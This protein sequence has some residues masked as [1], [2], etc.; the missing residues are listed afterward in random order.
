MKNNKIVKIVTLVLSCLLLIGAAI[1]IS[2]SATDEP[3][4]EI[5]AKNIS[6]EGAIKIL[7]A[8]DANNVPE[9]AEV[10]M[11]F[12]TDAEGDVAYEKAAHSEDITIGTETYK[13]FFSEGIAP[14]NMR[15]PLYA[16][17]VIVDAE[18]SVLAESAL[19]EYSIYTYAINRYLKAPTIDQFLLYSA[20]LDY[21][22]SVQ[23]MLVESG[24]MTE[25]DVIDNGGWANAYCGV[26]VATVYDGQV[27]ATSTPVFAAPGE[28]VEVT[29]PYGYADGV[30]NYIADANGK[31]ITK[32]GYAKGTVK[33]KNPG[34]TTCTANYKITGFSVRTFDDLCIDDTENNVNNKYKGKTEF[35]AQNLVGTYAANFGNAT[36]D[37]KYQRIDVDSTDASNNVYLV[38]ANNTAG[39]NAFSYTLDRVYEGYDKYVMQFDFNWH[40]RTDSK[41]D[42]PVFFRVD[43]KALADANDLV[44]LYL[45]DSGTASTTYTFGNVTLN[46]GEKYTLRFELIPHNNELYNLYLYVNGELAKEWINNSP[47]NHSSAANAISNVQYFYGMRFF[48]RVATDY[49]CEIDNVYVAAEGKPGNGNG[50][51]ADDALTYKYN[52][53]TAPSDYTAHVTPGSAKIADNAFTFNGY[54]ESL[55]IKNSGSKI[56]TK[57]VYET[58][59]KF[60][61]SAATSSS[62]TIAWWGLSASSGSKTTTFA[63]YTFQYAASNGKVDYYTIYRNDGGSSNITKLFPEEW[64]N[65]RIEYTPTT[66]YNGIVEF[67]LN[68]VLLTTYTASGYEGRGNI[69]NAKLDCVAH[70]FRGASY[71]GVSSLKISYA[72]TYLNATSTNTPG[73]GVYYNNAELAGTRYDGTELPSYVSSSTGTGNFKVTN[74]YI[75]TKGAADGNMGANFGIKNNNAVEGNVH[76]FEADI[77]LA[78]G[79]IT[80]KD[81]FGWFGMVAS[82]TRNKNE[83]FVS[84]SASFNADENNVITGVN[85]YDYHQNSTLLTT[86]DVG[87]WYNIR[88]VYTVTGEGKGDVE[89]Y[90]DNVLITSYSTNGYT[91]SDSNTEANN[92]FSQLYFE[93]R[94]SGS[95]GAYYVEFNVDNMFLGSF[96]EE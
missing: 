90:V 16:K 69:S 78:K 25:Q 28:E 32:N 71:S 20:T 65:I 93:I 45:N 23:K 14:K 48:N 7:Y 44:L 68:G 36:T 62:N 2:V 61:A 11:Y 50:I 12:Y 57:Y 55:G 5:K 87:K 83:E 26:N 92:M 51:Y 9:G 96:T 73:Q 60:S 10:K 63:S 21:G 91:V 30:F 18:G 84:L 52:D 24:R 82:D 95:S 54:G 42:S 40:G 58:D 67:Y 76:V 64:Y 34:V 46:K 56:G 77:R 39:G 86:L 89:L 22:A 41:G 88:F 47:K 8:V 37:T 3:T 49:S 59:V 6:Y 94:G 74:D 35:D 17:A 38:G 85:I 80:K 33:V 70:E 27:V 29:A 53:G 1:G 81:T 72:N 79:V 15:T 43:N 13:V 4:V 66:E 19:E 31:V 75:T